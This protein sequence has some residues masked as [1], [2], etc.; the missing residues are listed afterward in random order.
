MGK[1][2][3]KVFKSVLGGG[4]KQSD[5]PKGRP[6]GGPPG[7]PKDLNRKQLLASK[8]PVDIPA[9]LG[10]GVNMT[11]LQQRTQIASGGTSSEDPR[12][13]DPTTMGAYNQLLLNNYPNSLEDLQPIERQYIREVGGNPQSETTEGY[14]SA[15][16]RA[17]QSG[18][19]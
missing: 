6:A 14:L 2:V 16:R 12:Y 17:I 7:P 4:V 10:M 19:A 18:G 11:P 8:Q 5:G 15:L 3:G 13:R 1:S 9:F